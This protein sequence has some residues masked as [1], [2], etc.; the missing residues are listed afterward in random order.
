[1]TIEKDKVTTDTYKE[2]YYQSYAENEIGKVLNANE[3]SL[4]KFYIGLSLAL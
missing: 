2:K 1:M 3:K 4:V